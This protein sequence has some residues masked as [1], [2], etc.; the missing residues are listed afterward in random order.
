MWFVLSCG[1][2]SA[3]LQLLPAAL[4]QGG[5]DSLPPLNPVTMGLQVEMLY[6]TQT[7][8]DAPGWR[9]EAPPRGNRGPRQDMVMSSQ[10]FFWL[11]TSQSWSW[12][13]QQPGNS[14]KPRGKP[15]QSNPTK[16]CL[17]YWR[18]REWSASQHGRHL[19]SN[20]W[21]SL[22]SQKK[23]PLPSDPR[24]RPEW[25]DW[26]LPWPD[27]KGHVPSHCSSGG[28]RKRRSRSQ[29]I[30]VFRESP[31]ALVGSVESGQQGAGPSCHPRSAPA[32]QV[33]F[34]VGTPVFPR[35]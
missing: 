30:H 32:R 25:G 27:C 15:K 22:V 20:C 33:W 8:E 5:A 14:E 9:E 18:I 13:S 3:H 6:V 4:W 26:L 31:L 19:D 11:H 12:R 34:T 2:P 23:W 16:V 21:L 24:S 29:D 10:A 7:Q 28:W 35:Q 1:S 17:L